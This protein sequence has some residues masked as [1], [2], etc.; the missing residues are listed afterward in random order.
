MTS[1]LHFNVWKHLFHTHA[2]KMFSLRREFLGRQFFQHPEDIIPLYSGSRNYCWEVNCK[3]NSGFNEGNVFL[4]PYAHCSICLVFTFSSI[5]LGG[6]FFLFVLLRNLSSA[7]EIWCLS[8]DQV[9][10]FSW[11]SSNIASASSFLSSSRSPI[12][13]YSGLAQYALHIF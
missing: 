6:D 1:S 13:S 5:F 3:S 10:F 12:K 4:L 7:S 9:I 2:W 11:Y 8:Q